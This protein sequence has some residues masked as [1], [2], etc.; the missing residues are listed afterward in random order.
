MDLLKHLGKL[1]GVREMNAY[2]SIHIPRISDPFFLVCSLSL[3]LIH[4]PAAP[5]GPY[6]NDVYKIFGILDPL[7]PLSAYL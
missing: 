5:M 4:P 3:S 1:C 7:P 6:L 2:C